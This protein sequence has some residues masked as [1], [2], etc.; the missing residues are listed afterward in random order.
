[1]LFGSVSLFSIECIADPTEVDKMT[2][3]GVM[4]FLED[5][6]LEPDSKL[7][8]IIAW[9]FKAAAQCEFSRDEFTR[10]MMEIG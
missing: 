7:V 4:K 2:A 10:G 6:S 9:K 5:L 1:M 3:V 8:L